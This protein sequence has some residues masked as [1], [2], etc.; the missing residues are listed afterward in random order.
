[1]RAKPAFSRL[2]GFSL[3]SL[4]IALAVPGIG[5]A[6]AAPKV[7]RELASRRLDRTSQLIAA[8]LDRGF[9]LAAETR[10]PV[11]V[12][13]SAGAAGYAVLDRSGTVR[14]QRT[15]GAGTDARLTA[16]TFSHDTV[17]LFPSGVTSRSLTIT[18]QS[19]A[20]SRRVTMTRL[21]QIQVN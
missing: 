17:E 9:A 11:R 10:K 7:S 5:I 21:G 3:P 1:M 13:R 15:L 20:G 2:L 14:Q 18:L 6:V 4:L 12:V 16:M 19:G 8:D